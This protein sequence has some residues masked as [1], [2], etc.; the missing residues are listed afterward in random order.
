MKSYLN[1]IYDASVTDG[2][3]KEEVIELVNI[4]KQELLSN[5]LEAVYEE[6]KVKN[7]FDKTYEMAHAIKGCCR[8]IGAKKLGDFAELMEKC[9]SEKDWEGVQKYADYIECNADEFVKLVFEKCL[10]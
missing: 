8:N 3:E 2:L 5:L 4:F 1:D 10:D 7:D 9:C 6:L